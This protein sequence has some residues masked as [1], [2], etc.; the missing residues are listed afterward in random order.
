MA[1]WPKEECVGR[2][3]NTRWRFFATLFAMAFVSYAMRQNI[4]VAGEHMM[5]DLGISEIEMG[6]IFGAFI[7]GY[8]IFQ[9]PGGIFGERF[10]P[11]LVL[12]GLGMIWLLTTALTGLLPGLLITS[13][14]G[15]MV[16]LIAVRLLMG[17]SQ[18]PLFP[19]QALCIQS[20]FPPGHWGLPNSLGTTGY[21]LGAAATQPVVVW[22][23]LAFGWR[24][25]FFLLV[26]LGAAMF[27]LFWWYA[28]DR[29]DQHGGVSAAELEYINRDRPR[30]L[31]TAEDTNAWKRL[32]R[33]RETL[34]LALSYFCMNYVF[35]LFFTWFFHYLVKERGFSILE[36]GWLAAVPW[37]TGAITA[38]LGGWACDGLTA[39]WGP[40]WGCRIP[41]MTGLLSTAAFLYLGLYAGDAYMAVALLSLCYAAAQFTDAAFW[42]AQTFVAGPHTASAGGI[43][44]TGGNTP[45]IIVAPL[46]P[47]LAEHF[48]WVAA[49]STGVAVAAFGGLLWLFIRAD[50]P[51]EAAT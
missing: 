23:M 34:L 51:F 31:R 12:T 3:G 17:V 5:P 47:Y 21:S 46:M 27:A 41:A 42:Q 9:L 43:L 48:G 45:G 22:L 44:N 49:L 38:A 2:I 40:R 1:R 19:I 14:T 39:R 30:H 26:P 25:T 28:R 35:Y 15:I 13:T 50:R 11:R 18:A 4:H 10:G 37:V 6:W 32:L 36:T 8:T 24:S 33:N 20:W 29:P 7:W 16:S